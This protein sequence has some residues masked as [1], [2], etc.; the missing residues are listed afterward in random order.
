MRV[1]VGSNDG[2]TRQS[3]IAALLAAAGSPRPGL[4]VGVV[5]FANGYFHPKTVHLVRSDGSATAYVGSANLTG[6]GVALNVE[7]GITLDTRDGDDRG[8]LD[9]IG[10]AVDWWFTG[11]RPGLH[12]VSTTADLAPLVSSGILDVPQPPRPRPA[13]GS[14]TGGRGASLRPLLAIPGV[15]PVPP[16][17]ASPRG[18]LPARWTKKLSASDAQRKGAGNQRGSITLVKARAPIDP[19]TYFRRTLFGSAAWTRSR[20]GTGKPLEIAQLTFDVTILGRHLGAMDIEVSYAPNREAAQ[21]N[22]TSLLHLGPLTPHFAARNM[23]GRQITI[24][25]RA[26]GSYTLSVS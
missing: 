21:S 10:A 3:D 12:L 7:A 23:T 20:T 15:G 9:A 18:L 22:Y 4:R 5:S 11:P 16:T 1:L 6:A 24:E 25:R 13:T 14:G 26:N 19:T 17:P 2:T 8:V